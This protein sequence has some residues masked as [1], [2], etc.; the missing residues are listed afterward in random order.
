MLAPRIAVGPDPVAA[1]RTDVYVVGVDNYTCADLV[2]VRSVDGGRTFGV[3]LKAALCLGGGWIDTVVAPNGTL[4]VSA[5]GPR[6]YR[7]FNGGA[8]W[9]LAAALGSTADGSSLAWDPVSGD[10][11]AVWNPAGFHSLG[12]T[13]IAVSRDGGA[14]WSSPLSILGTAAQPSIAVHG[15]HVVVAVTDRS[16]SFGAETTGVTSSTD[17]GITWSTLTDLAPSGSVYRVNAPSAAVSGSG[18]FAVAWTA[19]FYNGP[20]SNPAYTNKTLISA[21][22]DGGTKWS[23]ASPAAIGGNVVAPSSGRSAIFDTVGRLFTA[24]HAYSSDLTTANVT[25]VSSGTNLTVFNES[26]FTIRFQN[27]GANSTQM[28]NLAADNASRVFV[29]WEI[30]SGLVVPG[31]DEGVFVRTVTGSATAQVA[32]TGATLAVRGSGLVASATATL[33]LRDPSTGAVV[34]SASWMGS[35]IGLDEIPPQNYEVWVDPGNG[36][37]RAGI[38]PIEPWGET[39]FTVYVQGGIISTPPAPFPWIPVAAFV[40][41]LAAVVAGALQYTR[42]TRE[43]VLQRKVRLLLFEYIRDHPGALFSQVRD[44]IGLQNGAAAYHLSV[45][46][47]QGFVHSETKRR[48]RWYYPSGDASLWKDLPVSPVQESI[49]RAVRERPGIAVRE[50]SRALNRGP[51]SVGYNVRALSREGL[52][53]IAREGLRVRCYPPEATSA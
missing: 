30:R 40:I 13:Y 45:L 37:V 53:R 10:V 27:T 34:R 51:S 6:I 11:Y 12:P 22:R 47:K 18:V 46:E 1:G 43:N 24:W 3:P 41:V 2:T 44:A 26:S 14:T 5:P 32:S 4:I 49:L 39:S 29:V 50:L 25:V 21:S 9:S 28:E 15:G 20:G 36:S 7:S 19:E 38:I 42:I 31:S 33:E 23:A 48:R 17:G 52:L 8:S 35:P 16:G